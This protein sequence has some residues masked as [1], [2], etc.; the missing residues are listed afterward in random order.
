MPR[1]LKAIG[2]V[3]FALYDWVDRHVE[4]R[5]VTDT[6]VA[7]VFAT[8]TAMNVFAAVIAV[9][10]NH[11]FHQFYEWFRPS[12][13]PIVVPLVVVYNL[14]VVYF[15]KNAKA[16]MAGLAQDETDRRQSRA[17]TL[18][19]TYFVLTIV[20]FVVAMLARHDWSK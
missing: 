19:W 3:T 18:L 8:C 1:F 2:D 5:S 15:Y 17:W 20:S 11:T 14:L 13:V 12:L 4:R 7:G 9:Y 16:R 10:G 6:L